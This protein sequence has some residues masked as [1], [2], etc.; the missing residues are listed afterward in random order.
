MENEIDVQWSSFW[1]GKIVRKLAF[2]RPKLKSGTMQYKVNLNTLQEI[3]N[4]KNLR[5][6]SEI[7]KVI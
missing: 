7:V 1:G 3:C 4:T 5:E 2:I 6:L